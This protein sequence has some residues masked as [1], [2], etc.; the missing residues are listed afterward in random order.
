MYQDAHISLGF[1]FEADQHGLSKTVKTTWDMLQLLCRRCMSILASIRQT[2]KFQFQSSEIYFG[3]ILSN[4][5]P[6]TTQ[7]PIETYLRVFRHSVADIN[8]L[9][10]QLGSRIKICVI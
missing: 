1:Q 3:E 9:N 4:F 10:L 2:K 7:S 5:Q 8:R 6:L